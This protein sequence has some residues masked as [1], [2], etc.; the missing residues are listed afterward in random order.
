VLKAADAG[1]KLEVLSRGT[2]K[3]IRIFLIFLEPR[4]IG[5][6]F[7]TESMGLSLFK[8]FWWGP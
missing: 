3:N 1:M 7:A 8:I 4:I 5:L 2:P 6:H